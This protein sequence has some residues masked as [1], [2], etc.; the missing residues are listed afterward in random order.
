MQDIYNRS[1]SVGSD[2]HE[3]VAF[4]SFFISCHSQNMFL[5]FVNN[6]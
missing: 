1:C 4:F 5:K 6:C 3:V 2:S